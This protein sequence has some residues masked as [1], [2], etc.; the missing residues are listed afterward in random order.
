MPAH[1]RLWVSAAERPLSPGEAQRL[2]ERVDAFLAGW[3]A[4]GAP[5]AGARDLVHDRFLLVAADEEATGVSGCSIDS[6]YRVLKELERELGVSLLDSSLVFYRDDTGEIRS[7]T[8]PEFRELAS[9][10]GVGEDS[11]VF[12]NTVTTVGALRSGGWERRMADSW[13]ARAFP[14]SGARHSA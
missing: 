1:A 6:L 3:H 2:L 13:H 11:I 9:T 10:G 14:A 4:H 12:D 5:V 8:R 7:A